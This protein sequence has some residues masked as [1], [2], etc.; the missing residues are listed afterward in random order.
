MPDDTALRLVVLSPEQSFM[1]DDSRQATDAVL[2]HLRMHGGQPRHR[3]NRLIFLA[4]DN[5]VLNRLRDATRVALA[6]ASIVEDVDED[7]LNIDQIQRKQAE[8]ESQAANAVLPR[9]ARECFK[10]LLCP[11]QDDPTA[12]KPAIES[13]PLNT[14]SGTAPSELERVCRENELVIETWSPIHLRAKLKELY[15]KESKPAVRAMAF[16]EDTLRYL[17]LP[18]L[19]S[20]DVLA[21]VVR[22]GAASKDFFGTAYA[23]ADGKYEGFHLG[24]GGVS[25]DDALLLIEPEAAKKYAIEEENSSSSQATGNRK[26]WCF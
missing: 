18:R 25:L 1:K 11:V 17:Y 9:A 14:T 7:R 8:K 24:D 2:E 5:A 19:K 21:A 3:T 20:R 16:W 6:W 4:A 12:T 15:W 26:T 10:W 22:T 13:F 23:E